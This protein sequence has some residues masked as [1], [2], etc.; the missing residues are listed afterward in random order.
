MCQKLTENSNYYY[1]VKKIKEI[2]NRCYLF[3]LFMV[4]LSIKQN[5][6]DYYIVI[7]IVFNLKKAS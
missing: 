1:N 6:E 4:C 2:T 5:I 3:N 7:K